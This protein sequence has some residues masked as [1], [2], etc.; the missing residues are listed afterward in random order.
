[1]EPE[2]TKTPAISRKDNPSTSTTS[3]SP[4]SVPFQRSPVYLMSKSNTPTAATPSPSGKTALQSVQTKPSSITSPPFR[5][6]PFQLAPLKETRNRVPQKKKKTTTKATLPP[7]SVTGSTTNPTAATDPDDV[8]GFDFNE[9]SEPQSKPQKVAGKAARKSRVAKPKQPRQP[10]AKK[11]TEPSGMRLWNEKDFNQRQRQIKVNVINKDFKPLEKP[12]PPPPAPHSLLSLA[13][14]SS[15]RSKPA[16]QMNSTALRGNSSPPE[17][18]IIDIEME[19]EENDNR[20]PS[21]IPNLSNTSGGGSRLMPWRYSTIRNVSIG[22]GGGNVTMTSLNDSNAENMN[23]IQRTASSSPKKSPTIT[24]PLH[25]LQPQ[26]SPMKEL[27][28]NAT[29][30]VPRPLQQKNRPSPVKRA[31]GVEN[32]FGFESDNE[33]NDE[34]NLEVTRQ[35]ITE[36]IDSLKKFRHSLNVSNSSS[37]LVA[38][39]MRPKLKKATLPKQVAAIRNIFTSTPQQ[40]KI[41]DAFKASTPIAGT[42]KQHEKEAADAAAASTTVVEEGDGK[43][44]ELKLF[45]S[46]TFEAPPKRNYSA[47]APRRKKKVD[48]YGL[49]EDEDDVS[50]DENEKEQEKSQ[51]DSAEQHRPRVTKKAKVQQAQEVSK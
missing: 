31:F 38:G 51:D 37:P 3:N 11:A 24:R 25:T 7:P 40:V 14:S 30:L 26:R 2:S 48:F 8:Y 44:E 45:E 17:I 34:D 5:A 18:Q 49:S 32:A 43:D 15:G 39:P 42:S 50:G 13:P 41:R 19:Q 16:P 22:G 12:I 23:P 46:L 28:P 21:K 9:S 29:I 35:K 27:N 1:M 20:Q 33:E 47:I 36:K 4:Q 10:R 6:D